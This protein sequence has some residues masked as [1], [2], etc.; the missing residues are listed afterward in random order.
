MI[1]WYELRTETFHSLR[2]STAE[3]VKDNIE[4]FI[5]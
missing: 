1:E 5:L 4:V 2:K 3:G